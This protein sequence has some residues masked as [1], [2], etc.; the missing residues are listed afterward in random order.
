MHRLDEGE[1]PGRL[2]LSPTD[3]ARFLGC[4]HATALDLR[5][6]LGRAPAPSEGVDEQLAFIA[7]RGLAHER[8]YL[9]RLRGEGRRVVVAAP[10]ADPVAAEAA[11]VAA[12]RHG[13][14]AIAQGTLF[15]G[16]WIGRADVLLRRELAAGEP[17]STYG[18]WAYDIVDTKL[19]RHLSAAALLQLA[20]Y[21]AR[22]HTL[23][24]VPPAR[25]IIVT[26]D[27]SERQWR[28]ADVQAY[29]ARARRGLEDFVAL[30]ASGGFEATDV[31][32][33]TAPVTE[34]VPVAA[35]SRCRWQSHCAQAWADADDLSLVAGMRHRHR[36]ALRDGGVATVAAL[37]AA[38]DEAPPGI[39]RT[40]YARLRRQARLQVAEREGGAAR[41]EL[42]PYAAGRGLARLPEPD[43]GDLYLD[44]E[45]DPFAAAGT[46]R[47]YLAGVLDRDG[48]F[49]T[50]WAHDS[51]AEARLVADLLAH[52][53]A[54]WRAHPGMHVYHYAP[55]ETAAL[56]RLTGRYGVAEAELDA[57]L[58]GGRFVDLYAVVKQGIRIGKSSYSLKKLEDLYW[59]SVRRGEGDAVAD[60][61]SSVVEYERWL[62]CGD[63]DILRRVADYNRED[64]RSTLAL[65]DWLEAR[66]SELALELAAA[67]SPDGGLLLPRPA[68]TELD[69]AGEGEG[70]AAERQLAW[71]LAEAG[72]ELFAGLLGW[73]RREDRPDWWDFFRRADLGDDDLVDDAAALGR[74]GEPEPGGTKLARTGRPTSLLWD[75]AFPTQSTRLE[76]GRVAY[77][78]DTRTGAGTVVALDGEAGRLTLSRGLKQ[79][80]AAPR[81][82]MPPGPLDNAVLRGSLA[83]QAGALL[84]GES[85]AGTRL[86]AREV[87]ADLA[88]LPGESPAEAVVRVG[89]GLD[90]QV[91]AVQG[92]PGAG[93]TYAAC[94]LI[95]ALLDAGRSVGVTAQSHAVIRNLL[96]GVGRPALHKVTGE[97]AAPS[98]LEGPG[99][100]REVGDNGEIAAALAD[101][102]ARL[103]GGTAWLWARPELAGSV[104]VLVIDEAGQ[105][106]LANAV[107]VAAAARSL[108][109]LGDPQQLTQPTK[110]EHPGGAGVTAL[111]HLIGGHDVIPADVGLF[112]DVS[113]R[114]HPA[115]TDLVS[116]ISYA[117]RLRSAAGRERQRVDLPTGRWSALSGAGLRWVPVEHHGNVADSAE[118]AV[119]V[120]DLV[121][122]LLGGQWV[123]EDGVSRTMTAADVLVVAPYNSHVGRLAAAV[124]E[125]V[126]VG[127]VDRFQGQQAPAVI[128]ATGS[129]SAAEAPRGL[130]FLYD[131]HRL[132][133]AVSRAK[134]LAIWVGSPALLDAAAA[135]PEQ[136]RLVNALC[137]L[138]DA[139][140]LVSCPTG[141]VG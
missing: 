115:I 12:M 38:G 117:G 6:A 88:V 29:A 106:S 35:C 56:K 77:D 36:A 110:A 87:P 70:A 57:L 45:G 55:Y 71:E 92:P 46:G 134:A 44:F 25:L 139:A 133:V 43:P 5:V 128:Y 48:A 49:A 7:A 41:Y 53:V 108:V 16:R 124:P 24:G 85:T 78:V 30:A 89:L 34:P 129:S 105:F 61:L 81:G 113:F 68:A 32:D 66:R 82:L 118:E 103:V 80:A 9:E 125:G 52:L 83:R 86:V 1:G 54:H 97:P 140:K 102:S 99:G 90:G 100:V 33:A 4:A 95:R 47:E 121:Q 111:G 28:V 59:G 31:L 93:K 64:V 37:A 51:A 8:A 120:G 96:D 123:D 138:A 75:Y 60:A 17:R 13:A 127:T 109:L 84:A 18:D 130:S 136:V 62:E 20:T 3:L 50:W 26:G 137:C 114:M 40:T 131:V 58:R 94:A 126:R 101:G 73:H 10:S 39:S 65:H 112:L 98:L 135:T 104:D 19:A 72:H 122:G 15:D 67:G 27:G 74:L 119:V 42:L 2:V 14:D 21:A 132:N 91:L 76:V 79:P 11:T 63:D 69:D 107:A 141:S 22:L 23:Q 116:G